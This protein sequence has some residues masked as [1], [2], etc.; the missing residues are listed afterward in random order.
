MK[1]SKGLLSVLLSVSLA[2]I[3]PAAAQQHDHAAKGPE[4]LGKVSFPISCDPSLQ[5]LFN[6]AVAT[7]HSFWYEKAQEAFAAVAQKDAGCGLAHWGVAM[8]LYHPLWVAPNQTELQ[9]GWTAVEKAK[10]AGA[11]TAR[12]R[13]YIAAIEL[14]YKDADKLDHR[15]RAQAY[16]KTMEQL[17]LRYPDD[18]EAA[19]FYALS[20]LGT[21]TALGPDKALA[22]QKQAGEIVEKLFATQ[23]EHPGLAHYIIHSYDYPTLAP[24]ALDPARRYA[25]IAPDSPHALHMPSHIF[26]R[27]GLWEESISSN[28][29]SA[30][31]ARAVG[32]TGDELHA[33]DYLMYAYLQQAQDRAARKLLDQVPPLRKDQAQYFAGL[34]ATATMPARYAIERHR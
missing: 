11:K 5:L 9:K 24:R 14:F 13:D 16:E 1:Y 32:A 12:E 19:I 23:P 20:L 18:Q 31:A 10:A 28:L 17:H 4:R 7:L 8:T 27:L 22:R 3:T 33:L 25:K 15:T 26:T 29:A 21:A 34:Y 2:F 6:R 30:A